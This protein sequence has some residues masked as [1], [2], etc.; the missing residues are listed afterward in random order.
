[1][2]RK[3]NV[4]RRKFLQGT[5]G[6]A[7]MLGS[8]M[9]NISQ[10]SDLT[11]ASISELSELIRNK[12][13]SPVEVT[14]ATLD[15]IEKLN[16]KLNAYI[17]VTRDLALKSAQD[18]EGEIQLKK[19]RGPLHGVPIA[20]KDLFD[21]AGIKTTAGSNVFKDRVPAQDA[22]VIRRLKAAGAVIVG[23][24]NMHEFAFGGSSLVTAFE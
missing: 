15:R 20:V 18:A 14:R 23:K 11:F 9:Q 8:T 13:I 5:I 3:M 4:S 10:K 22:E 1:M 17:T 7:A 24:T 19:W 6:S 2:I 16:P 21:T 12:K